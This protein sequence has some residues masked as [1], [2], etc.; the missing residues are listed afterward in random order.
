MPPVTGVLSLLPCIVLL[1]AACASPAHAAEASAQQPGV[2]LQ[3]EGE[4]KPTAPYAPWDIVKAGK[5]HQ[6]A[7]GYEG[8]YTWW[9]DLPQTI[10]PEGFDLQLK[11][12]ANA[13]S[14]QQLAT[15]IG[16]IGGVDFVKSATDNTP[17]ITKIAAYSA[18]AVDSKS[19]SVHIKPQKDYKLGQEVKLEIGPS[20]GPS[21]TYTYKVVSIGPGGPSSAGPPS[22]AGPTPTGTSAGGPGSTG[23]GTTTATASQLLAKLKTCTQIS[24][25][26]YAINAEAKRTVPVCGGVT[27]A[28][29]FT[30]DMDV[31]CDGVVTAHCNEKTDRNFQPRTAL[32]P[33]GKPLNAE[34]TRYVVIPKNSSIFNFGKNDIRLGTVVAIIYK[35]VLTYAVVGDIGPKAIIG[36]AS[37]ATA[38]ALGINPDPK[39]GGVESGVTYIVFKGTRVANPGSNDSIDTAGQAAAMKFLH[40][41]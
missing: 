34:T 5:V 24:K 9:P 7:T 1:A 12:D 38:Q 18:G 11:V 20:Y 15:G 28:I 16:I 21:V 10:G 23:P 13:T 3:M 8:T 29:F 39:N 26:R 19:F 30:A 2:V 36:E 25:G 27:G 37:Y 33:G 4:P 14:Q 22:G 32:E 31:D 17:A 35:G 6:K 41:N 40:D